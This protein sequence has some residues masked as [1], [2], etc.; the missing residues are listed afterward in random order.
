MTDPTP[1][2]REEGVDFVQAELFA[3]NV[4]PKVSSP[5]VQ[6][7][8]RAYLALRAAPA[9]AEGEDVNNLR[10]TLSEVVGC[11]QAAERDAMRWLHIL[12]HGALTTDEDG[13][14]VLALSWGSVDAAPLTPEERR[15]L[16]GDAP[17]ERGQFG[18]VVGDVLNRVLDA[19]R[20]AD[21]FGMPPA[22]PCVHE[23]LLR[24]PTSPRAGAAGEVTEAMVEAFR[25]TWDGQKTIEK[26][27]RERIRVSL[28]AALR[29][30][31]GGGAG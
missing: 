3:H 31:R 23:R 24:T 12:H 21:D 5:G 10:L 14:L 11:C 26:D 20:D 13:A 29:A 30:A 4:A 8:A 7:L 9:E 2:A 18:V 25:A 17:N 19:T 16:A 28:T 22:P 15:I 6:N 1:R 27:N